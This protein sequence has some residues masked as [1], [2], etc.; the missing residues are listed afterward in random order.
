MN[1]RSELWLVVGWLRQEIAKDRDGNGLRKKETANSR[2]GYRS[3]AAG[4]I[5]YGQLE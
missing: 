5:K 4:K 3:S 1:D 2:E